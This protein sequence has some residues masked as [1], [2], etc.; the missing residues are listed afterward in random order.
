MSS[1]FSCFVNA[2]LK[3][4]RRNS[5]HCPIVGSSFPRLFAPRYEFPESRGI[6]S[7][8]ESLRSFIAHPFSMVAKNPLPRRGRTLGRVP[9]RSVEFLP[10]ATSHASKTPNPGILITR[11][12]RL[13]LTPYATTSYVD[14]NE[15][16]RNFPLD[17]LILTSY[18]SPAL[19]TTNLPA[20]QSP[21][22]STGF[23]PAF[24]RLT[25][26]QRAPLWS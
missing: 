20:G 13:S 22:K 16:S 14:E 15:I 6:A 26:H 9:S 25:D 11:W 17:P 1:H 2:R 8:T 19:D 24:S 3:C 21:A 7:R 5:S 18:A 12:S 23:P 4:P 10:S